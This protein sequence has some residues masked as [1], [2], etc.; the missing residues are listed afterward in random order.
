MRSDN[1]FQVQQEALSKVE[2]ITNQM[3]RGEIDIED[4]EKQI[5]AIMSALEPENLAFSRKLERKRKLLNA[6]PWLFVLA[7]F[8]LAAFI[9]IFR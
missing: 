4:A 5:I 3:E 7:L 2:S 1:F 8:F 9:F 6:A